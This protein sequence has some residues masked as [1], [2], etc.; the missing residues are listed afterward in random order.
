[1]MPLGTMQHSG[2]DLTNLIL[3]EEL[4][5]KGRVNLFRKYLQYKPSLVKS[6]LVMES[7]LGL[8]WKANPTRNVDKLSI[9][10]ACFFYSRKPTDLSYVG[11]TLTSMELNNEDLNK[12]EKKMSCAT[13]FKR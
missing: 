13:L 11:K 5:R 2:P 8:A 10:T 7:S 3:L 4:E 6:K 9:L 1:M 12:R